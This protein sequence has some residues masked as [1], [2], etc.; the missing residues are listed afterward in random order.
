MKIKN[1]NESVYDANVENVNHLDPEKDITIN[2]VSVASIK[3]PLVVE[4]DDDP[5]V[6]PVQG[7]ETF[8]STLDI[9]TKEN[10][11]PEPLEEGLDIVEISPEDYLTGEKIETP[12]GTFSVVDISEKDIRDMGYGYHHSS[13]DSRYK[14]MGNGSQAFAILVESFSIRQ[15]ALMENFICE[16]VPNDDTERYLYVLD[17]LKEEGFNIYDETVQKYAEHISDELLK[18]LEEDDDCDFYTWYH[19]AQ[20]EFP[21]DFLRLEKFIEEGVLAEAARTKTMWDQLYDNLVADIN[22]DNRTKAIPVQNKVRYDADNV[23]VTRDGNIIVYAPEFDGLNF[24]RIVA[25][26][27]DIPTKVKQ[28]KYMSNPN[29]KWSMTFMVPD[30]VQDFGEEFSEDYSDY[31]G[32]VGQEKLRKQISDLKIEI[33]DLYILADGAD[34]DAEKSAFYNEIEELEVQYDN[35]WRQVQD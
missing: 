10:K 16:S 18:C 4:P 34:D 31:A 24:A 1:M 7:E 8:A 28:E 20:D 32:K 22:I 17:H 6:F 33:D 5:I 25:D 12:R 35:L 14:I 15:K 19:S 3:E 9:E 11:D 30:L 26:H 23:G 2:D 13:D 21:G 27:F 29:W